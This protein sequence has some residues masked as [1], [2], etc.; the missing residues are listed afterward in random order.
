[1]LTGRTGAPHQSPPP[2]HPTP[3][4]ASARGV[5]REAGTGCL[6]RSPLFLMPRPHGGQ[7]RKHSPGPHQPALHR[8]AHVAFKTRAR[9]TEIPVSCG[10]GSA[11]TGPPHLVRL[12]EGGCQAGGWAGGG[13][14]A[15]VLTGLSQSHW[16]G[17]GVLRPAG[18]YPQRHLLQSETIYPRC[19]GPWVLWEGPTS[20]LCPVQLWSGRRSRAWGPGTRTI[21]SYQDLGTE[22]V[23][24]VLWT[25]GGP[26]WV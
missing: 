13:F 6:G 19:Q 4:P 7:R 18:G 1:M 5:N 12:A 26:R 20:W 15:P 3:D 8:R 16:G 24:H 22:P 14:S 2:Q 10:R 21:L 17:L 25:W 23:C 9:D 11:A